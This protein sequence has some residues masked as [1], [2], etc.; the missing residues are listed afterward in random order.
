MAMLCIKGTY[1]D[2]CMDCQEEEAAYYCPEC[3]EPLEW[4]DQVFRAATGDV[5]G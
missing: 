4:N 3:G 2:G 1:C 5:L